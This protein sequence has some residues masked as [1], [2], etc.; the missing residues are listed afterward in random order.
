MTRLSMEMEAMNRAL[1]K[2]L[3]EAYTE[4]E[5]CSSYEKC[6]N[7]FNDIQAEIKYATKQKMNFP[8]IFDH[9]MPRYIPNPNY[10]ILKNVFTKLA[11]KSFQRRVRNSVAFNFI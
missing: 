11:P 6:V 7:I 9:V 8:E 10:R 4:I 5:I 3:C 2:A 1:E